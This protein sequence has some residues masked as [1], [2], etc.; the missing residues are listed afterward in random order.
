MR[1]QGVVLAGGYSRRFGQDK[2][3]YAVEGRPMVARVAGALAAAGLD[4]VIVARDLRLEGLGLP[5]LVEPDAPTRHPLWG[6]AAA[7]AAYPA[8]LVAPCDLAWLDAA[9]VRALLE[10]APPAVAWDGERVHP[11]LGVYPDA[12][13]ERALT[14]AA[15][16][17]PVRRFA[18]GAA[19]VPVRP[20]AVGNLNHPPEGGDRAGSGQ[21]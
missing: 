16:G 21:G 17:W 20:E 6:L 1:P 18:E 4:V 12:W 10:A 14:H 15:E 7:L 5:V 11:L 9:T 8:V 3:L 19:L 13:R 2:A